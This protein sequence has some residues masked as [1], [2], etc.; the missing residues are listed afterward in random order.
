MRDL[1]AS[2]TCKHL[3][4]CDLEFMKVAQQVPTSLKNCCIISLMSAMDVVL[5]YMAQKRKS[6]ETNVEGYPFLS[7]EIF[8]IRDNARTMLCVQNPANKLD[9]SFPVSRTYYKSK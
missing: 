5:V 7:P 2:G 4:G 6:G 3:K 8:D 1:P 9:G